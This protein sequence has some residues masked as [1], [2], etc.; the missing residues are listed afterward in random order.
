M[1]TCRDLALLSQENHHIKPQ[2][3]QV[4]SVKVVKILANQDAVVK[5]PAP[6]EPQ[7]WAS[8]KAKIH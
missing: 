3:S 7:I 8:G 4:A 6:K 5:L 2:D 1:K